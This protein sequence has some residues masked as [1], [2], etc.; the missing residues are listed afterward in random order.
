MCLTTHWPALCQKGLA[1]ELE[2]LDMFLE[3]FGSQ[4]RMQFL[5]PSSSLP[6]EVCLGLGGGWGNLFG[7][8]DCF[9]TLLLG[10][11]KLMCMFLGK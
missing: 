3:G 5:L 2:A 6:P 10:T 4:F 7:S 1:P 8:I 9:H 11:Q